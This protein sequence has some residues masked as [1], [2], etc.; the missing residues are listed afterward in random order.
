MQTTPFLILELG[1]GCY[2]ENPIREISFA[3]PQADN[4]SKKPW[5]VY[6][7]RV[8]KI[9]KETSTFKKNWWVNLPQILP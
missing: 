7:F 6:T 2:D 1:L 5:N 9:S 3:K 4:T 8:L